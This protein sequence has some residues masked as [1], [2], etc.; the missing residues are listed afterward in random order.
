MRFF[1][2]F[3]I[4][5]FRYVRVLRGA[6]LCAQAALAV[7]LVFG[8]N[9]LASLPSFRFRWDIDEAK[10]HTLSLESGM[11]LESLVGKA[12][13]DTTAENPW[14][15]VVVTFPRSDFGESREEAYGKNMM[16]KRIVAL[17]DNFRYKAESLGVP[18]FIRFEEGDLVKNTRLA[19]EMEKN[20]IR[21]IPENAAVVVLSRKRCAV[22]TAAELLKIRR[23]DAGNPADVDGFRGEEAL[24]AA[25][26]K[27]ADETVPVVYSLVGHGEF[28][29]ESTDRSFGLSSFAEQLRARQI[30][31]L[32]LNLREHKDVPED[33]AMLLI[34]NPRIPVDKA[35]EKKIGRYL[36]E[37][38]GRVLLLSGPG[39]DPG[40]D[41][42]LFDWGIQ[43]ADNFVV[44]K[45]PAKLLYDGNVAVNTISVPAHKT[46]EILAEQKI[47]LVASQFRQV[48]RDVGSADDATR[49]VQE[50]VFSSPGVNAAGVPTSWG[51]SEYRTPPYRYGDRMSDVPGP[52]SVVAV[53]ERVAG[54]RLGFNIPGGRLVAVGAGDIASNAQLENGGNKTFLFN[55]VNWLIDRDVY[56]NIP[57][58]PI[59]DFRLNVSM[60][61]LVRVAWA[62]AVVPAAVVLLGL[63]VAFW[64][65]RI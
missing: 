45:D 53:A 21:K 60:P 59:S 48:R 20:G 62:F 33:A 57:P 64:R 15:R 61:D 54:T 4:E 10:S 8:L 3:K 29:P 9:Y 51:E 46:T 49:R 37:R 28:S 6:N 19:A 24:M 11:F 30:R 7:L 43:L 56:L 16:R 50:L 26:L 40:L 23:D 55:A 44:E 2:L 5:D 27:V 12:P 32:T 65:R 52:V 34:A 13:A 42:L 63:L 41:D 38:N 36:R 1:R 14:I 31:L 18:G 22:I 17:T 39:R 35:D 25:I 47:P 58:R